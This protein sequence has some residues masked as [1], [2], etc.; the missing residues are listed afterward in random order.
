MVK[1]VRHRRRGVILIDA[2][3]GTIL[4]GISLAAIIGLAGRALSSQMTGEELQT[5]AMLLNEQL[6]LVIA[7]GPD[8]YASRFD[9]EG[10]CDEPYQ[11]FRYKLEFSGGGGGQA[12]SVKATVFWTTAGRERSESIQ[13]LVAPRLGDE[14]DPDRRPPE[15]VEREY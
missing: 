10:A 8:N 6:N 14:P 15:T 9:A 1:R 5:A 4:L 13:T 11:R 12:Y 3:I 7:R 2:I